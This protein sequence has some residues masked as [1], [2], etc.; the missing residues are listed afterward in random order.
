MRT[1]RKKK[2]RKREKKEKGHDVLPILV[3]LDDEKHF[4]IIIMIHAFLMP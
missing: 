4:T 3:F 2:K 1:S